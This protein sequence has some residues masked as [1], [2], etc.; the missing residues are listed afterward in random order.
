MRKL[1]AAAAVV[2]ILGFGPQ[3]GFAQATRVFVSGHG[4]D[5]NPCSLPAPCRSFQAAHNA[6]AAGGEIDVLD[7]GGYGAVTITKSVSILG[8]GFSGVSVP[9]G[10]VAI[11]INA[12]SAVVVN[13]NGVLIEGAGIGQKGILFNGSGTLTM[14]D[15]VIRNLTDDGIDFIPSASSGL[16]VSHSRVLN[17]GGYGI[18]VRPTGSATATAVFD[19]VTMQY[20]SIFDFGLLLDAT[21]TTGKAIGTATDSNSSNNGGGFQV[22]GGTGAA[23]DS[24]SLMLVR[25]VAANNH[26]G[27]QAGGTAAP[28]GVIR[29]TQVTITGNAVAWDEENT[30]GGG[31]GLFSYGDNNID[32]NGLFNETPFTLI[33]H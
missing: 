16:S 12:A 6:V 20:N 3:P 5:T 1:F 4:S 30:T 31:S 22:K 9:S 13:L 28:T 11:F 17:N 24:A 32:G 27:V 2:G 14:E 25:S 23:V 10:G 19:G 33:H 8:H 26:T 18:V 21:F 15:C 7:P 29:M